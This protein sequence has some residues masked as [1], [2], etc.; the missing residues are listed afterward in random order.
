V[1]VQWPRSI[2]V[3]PHCPC[4]D[5][6]KYS[7]LLAHRLSFDGNN[8]VEVSLFLEFPISDPVHAGLKS[9]L[10]QLC[11]FPSLLIINES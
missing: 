6:T 4:T 10:V 2:R 1:S 7:L 9:L 3:R 5:I 8:I 11:M